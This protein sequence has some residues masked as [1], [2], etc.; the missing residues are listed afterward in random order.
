M[1]QIR[2]QHASV[3]ARWQTAAAAAAIAGRRGMIGAAAPSRSPAV[4]SHVA[5]KAPAGGRTSAQP[6]TAANARNCS[7]SA[8]SYP[9]SSS[10]S[11]TAACSAARR[12]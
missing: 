7:T 12:A 8:S 5:R 9:A 10:A 3:S 6:V 2:A 4:S 11:S 1:G